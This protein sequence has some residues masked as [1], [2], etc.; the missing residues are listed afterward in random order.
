MRTAVPLTTPNQIIPM[1]IHPHLMNS[2]GFWR[3]IIKPGLWASALLALVAHPAA[4]QTT[5]AYDV[6]TDVVYA[7]SFASGQNGGFGFGAWTISISGSGGAFI[8][9]NGPSGKSFDLWNQSVN[10]RTIAVR[11]FNSPLTVGQA[12]SFQRR[13][14]NLA[15][16]PNT[17]AVMLQ[18]ASGNT[19]FSF[20]HVGGDNN[21][22]H[23]ADASTASGTATGFAYNY[24]QFNSYSFK[25]TSPTT[26]LFRNLT[27]GA[28]LTGTISGSIAQVT[29]FRGNGATTSGGGQDFQFDLLQIVSDPV[30]FSSAF[31]ANGSYSAVRTNVSLLAVDGANPVNTNTIVLKVDGNVVTPGISKAAGIAT[32]S[33]VPGSPLSVGALH[34]ASVTL[35]D[36]QGNSFTNTWSFTTGYDSLPVTVG[37]P[38]TTGGGNDIILFKADGEGWLGTNYNASS[39]RTIYLRHSMVFNDL[40]GEVADGTG[41]CY[42]GLHLF[43]GGSGSGSGTE[44]L[45]TGETWQRNTWS[46]D[47]KSGEIALNPAT[48]VVAGEWHTIVERIDFSPIGNSSVKVWLDPDFS[49]TEDNQPT[50]PLTATINNTFDNIRLRCG[51]GTATATWTNVTVGYLASQV[52]FPVPANPTFQATLP[53]NG[54]YSVPIATAISSQ[55]VIGGSPITGISLKV[56]GTTVT[57]ILSTNSGIITVSYQPA[58]P[59][60]AGLL[61]TV[62]LVVTDNN[63]G[64]FTNAWSF[65]TGYASLPATVA[66]P[67]T[68]GGGNDLTLFSAAGDPW[69]GSNYNTNSSATLYARYSMV[70]N[71]LN[72]ESGSGGGYGGLHF[73]QDNDQRLIA[74]NAWVS[75]NWS[76]DAAASQQDLSPL[77]FVNLGE[78]HTIVVRTE[79]VAGTN[80]VVKVWLDPDFNQTEANQPN[81]PLVLNVNNNF[82]NI[83]LRCGNGTANA[84]WSN[85]VMAASATG[86]GFPPS[87]DVVFDNQF[88]ANGETSAAVGTPLSVR[89]I[90]GTSGIKTSS[91]GMTLDGN[92]VTPGFTV[93][94]NG[95]VAI[96]YQPASPLA[97]SSSHTVSVSLTDLNDVSYFTSWSFTVDAYPTL[98]L[99]FEGPLDVTGG[100]A[101]ITLYSNL[102]G[103][104]DGN[105]QD[106]SSNTLYT[107]FSMTFLDLNNENGGGGG[108]GG[109]QFLQGNGERLIIGNAWTSLNWSLDADGNQMDLLPV[110]PVALGE[111]HTLVV[112]TD[113]KAGTD[114]QIKVWLDPDFSRTEGGQFQAP[115]SLTAN[116]TFDNL[117][118]RCGNGSAYAQF[119]NIV[120][121]ATAPGVGFAA[122]VPP[123]A[124]TIQNNQLSWTS[125]GVLQEAPAVTG[126]WA[127]SA[128]QGNPQALSA[129]NAATFYR[130]RQ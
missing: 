88:P 108:F 95:N 45:M 35:A 94:T 67:V 44:R 99:T 57:P 40:N 34:M 123:A 79:Y 13:I 64:L 24:Q 91:I 126:P 7:S 49:Q 32:I 78:W 14:N 105:Y 8:Q 59:L 119:T 81:P 109:L 69:V 86:V 85:I 127:D 16:S 36:S 54:T 117:R 30:T 112:R 2:R 33:Y 51:N 107:R 52:G 42:G 77:T 110:L 29:F 50:P 98:P 113:F 92:P 122:S 84:T 43:N 124:L 130:L 48:T 80:D 26:Y 15:G 21:D 120:L 10:S 72:N 68:T 121:A 93:N 4:A 96:S 27:T 102:N 61:H 82:N 55:I 53:A 62:E 73:M 106:N 116:S 71:D 19:L 70:F 31:P 47:T 1:P 39:S 128:N 129:T 83:R 58:S 22:G 118:L 74:G 5:N 23:Y 115:V 38:I 18:D 46:A 9:N 3:K 17:N 41:G 28:S 114:D 90:P 12:F 103:W 125:T 89:A 76:L 100:G 111:W 101:G 87:V 75:L 20:W 25:L 11:P 65:N 6:A 66:G 104:I 37:G 60:T 97:A 56:D 63:S